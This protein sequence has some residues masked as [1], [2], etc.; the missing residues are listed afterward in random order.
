M[1]PIN[2]HLHGSVVSEG[3]VERFF[4]LCSS[5]SAVFLCSL[6][7]HRFE[8]VIAR[9]VTP[10]PAVQPKIPMVSLLFKSVFPM[11]RMMY[12]LLSL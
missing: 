10:A 2:P 8:S 7:W 4:L 1:A 9:C 11:F 6:E 5:N 3:I 12:Q